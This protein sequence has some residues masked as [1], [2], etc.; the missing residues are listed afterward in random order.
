M[1]E[2]PYEVFKRGVLIDDAKNQVFKFPMVASVDRAKSVTASIDE[3][4][5]NQEG[6]PFVA[7]NEAVIPR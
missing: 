6:C 5:N 2:P 7:V 1:L 4:I 3:Q